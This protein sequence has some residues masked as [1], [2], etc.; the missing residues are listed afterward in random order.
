MTTFI[1]YLDRHGNEIQFNVNLIQ[2]VR[3]TDYTPEGSKDTRYFVA[4]CYIGAVP[5]DVLEF[6]SEGQRY[7]WL[8]EYDLFAEPQSLKSRRKK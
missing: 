7:D 3:I 8:M 1:G 2:K 6:D 4:L 5:D